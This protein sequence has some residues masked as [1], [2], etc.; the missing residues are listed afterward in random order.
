VPKRLRLPVA[1]VAALV[2]AEAAVL[3]MRPRLGLEPVDAAPRDYFSAAQI[4]KAEAFRSGQ[5]WLYGAQVAVELL[6]LALIVR[7]PPKVLRREWRRPVLGG[8]AVAA[9]LSVA[10]AAATLPIR[11]IARERAKDV[12]LVTQDW[13]GYAGDQVKGTL[14]ALVLAGAGGALLVFG[15]RRFRRRWW[16]PGAALVTAWGVVMIYLS[17]VVLDPIFNTFKPL[18]AGS[19]RSAVLELARKADVKVGEVYE[20][21]ASRR[22]SAANAYVTG[23]GQT[24][25]VVIFDTL[26]KEFTPQEVK[27]VV[28]HELGHVHHHDVPHGLLYLAIVAPFG[29]LAVARLGERFAPPSSLGTAAAVPGTVLAIALVTPAITAISNQLSRAVETRADSFS[30]GLTRD[31]ESMIEFQKRITVQNVGDPEPP[32]A[33]HF[34]LGT[35]PTTMQ[36]I[37]LA[38]AFERELRRGDR[39]GAAAG[40]P[41]RGG[42]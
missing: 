4:E 18:P 39:A 33:V 38:L 30:L 24:K 10:V 1:V 15:M 11:A 31:P 5:L 27:L 20:M 19:T 25:R 37:G 21:D 35:H 42:S 12:G 32:P 22:T 17:P 3:V 28:A 2:V 6:L 41:P 13:V 7:R 29:M 23:L 14:I 36:R 9:G 40:P 34:L 26:L 16:I 8:A